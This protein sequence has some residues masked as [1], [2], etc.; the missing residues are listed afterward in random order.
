M[1]ICIYISVSAIGAFK[2][3]VPFRGEI[4]G[5]VGRLGL[6][7]GVE[8]SLVTNSENKT[9]LTTVPSSLD[10]TIAQLR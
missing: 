5:L 2:M 10:G 9:A 3:S 1:V 7:V 8:T 6:G 4:F